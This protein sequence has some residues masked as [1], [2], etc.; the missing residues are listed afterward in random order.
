MGNKNRDGKKAVGK[1]SA[2]SIPPQ[3]GHIKLITDMLKTL[4]LQILDP[5]QANQTGASCCASFFTLS[6]FR[7]ILP[8]L[9]LGKFSLNS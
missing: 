8:T 5:L 6:S 9:D 4:H 2:K 3:N 1:P 7:K